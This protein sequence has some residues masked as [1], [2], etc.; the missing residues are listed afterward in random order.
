[1]GPVP[2]MPC[3]HVR[4]DA[5]KTPQPAGNEAATAGNDDS[6]PAVDEPAPDVTA[7]AG[8][9]QRAE[10]CVLLSGKAKIQLTA[11][12]F[13]V[14]CYIRPSGRTCRTVGPIV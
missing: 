8:A 11:R 9:C 14:S 10:S 12:R 3:R 5:V 6:R 4:V 2:F 13:R 1:M 7:R